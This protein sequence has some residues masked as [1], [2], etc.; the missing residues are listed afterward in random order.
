MAQLEFLDAL[1]ILGMMGARR[2]LVT[3]L[4]HYVFKSES[5]YGSPTQVWQVVPSPLSIIRE[6]GPSEWRHF[7]AL[8]VIVGG[9]IYWIKPRPSGQSRLSV[10]LGRVGVFVP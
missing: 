9:I 4:S 8:F 3:D 6:N 2:Y 7:A 1:S 5:L 10:W